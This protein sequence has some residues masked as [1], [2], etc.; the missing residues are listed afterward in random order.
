MDYKRVEWTDELGNH[1]RNQFITNGKR[2]LISEK[3]RFRH[4]ELP[5][6]F[7]QATTDTKLTEESDMVDLVGEVKKEVRFLKVQRRSM[8]RFLLLHYSAVRSE[9]ENSE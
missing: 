8:K 9:E 3:N 7:F 1:A 5:N 6:S 4:W 2:C